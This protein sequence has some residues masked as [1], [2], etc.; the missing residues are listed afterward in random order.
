MRLPGQARVLVERSYARLPHQAQR[1]IRETYNRVRGSVSALRS[2][3]LS[4]IMPV[5]N[6]ENYLAEAVESVLSQ[7]YRHLELI[8]VDDGSTDTSG[9]MCDEFA[10]RDRRVRVIHKV[11]G[12]LGAARN[13]G[14]EAVRGSYLC[15][16][17]SDD[18]VLPGAYATMMKSILDSG[19]DIATGNVQRRRGASVYQAWNQSRSHL[20][21]QR[22]IA[23]ADNPTLLFDT[24][25]WN[26]IFRTDFWKRYVKTFPEKKLYED[27]L[28]MFTAFINARSIDIISQYVYIW[29]VRDEGDSIT[30]RL[31]EPNNIDDRFEMI[32]KI[33]ADI[34]ARGMQ[35]SLGE[36][37]LL[38]ILEGDLWIYV[39]EM[40]GAGDETIGRIIEYVKK[41][42]TSAPESVRGLIA[43]ERRI[44]YWLLEHDRVAEVALFR[45]WYATISNSPPL[46]HGSARLLLDVSDCPVPLGRM[47]D[48]CRDMVLDAEGIA[49]VTR[50]S[51]A[52][53]AT[54]LI[55]GYAYTKYV[56]TGS[57]AITVLARE[58]ATG[59]VVEFGATRTES[60][61]AMGHA[62]DT[63]SAHDHDGF[64]CTVDLQAL[65]GEVPDPHAQWSFAVRI[66]DGQ[67]VRT[68][69]LQKIW[70]GGSAVVVGGQLLADR[71][72]ALVKT[73]R[74]LPLR[75]QY[76]PVE[77][78]AASVEVEQNRVRV[79]LDAESPQVTAVQF[80]TGRS[81]PP[82]VA[83]RAA[84]GS[85]EARFPPTDT[86]HPVR[87]WRAF[88]HLGSR[89][90]PIV[91]PTGFPAGTGAN[92]TGVRAV[93]TRA[94]RLEVQVLKHAAVIEHTGSTE[95]GDIEIAGALFGVASDVEFGI[96]RGSAQ[97][98]MWHPATIEN[99]QFR[100]LITPS[101]PDHHGV[102]RP[103][104]PGGYSVHARQRVDMNG[105]AVVVQ[106]LLSDDA[107]AQLP[108]TH[109]SESLK[110]KLVRRSA[111]V[112]GADIAAPV[113]DELLGRYPQ[114]SL[115]AHYGQQ[116]RQLEDAVFFVVDR[117]SNASDSA[118]AIHHELR[119]R[120]SQL[121]LYWGV[122]G[123]HVA[124]PEGGIPIIKN[125]EQWYAKLNTARYIV[126]NYGGVWGLTKD[127]EQR[128]L[129][130]WHG[131]PYKY[132]GV[133]EARHKNAPNS[134]L[135]QIAK[136]ASEWDALV[137]PSPYFS[138]LASPEFL[139]QGAILEFGYPRNDRLATGSERERN[140]LRESLG[141]PLGAPVLLYA[142]TYRETQ[143][144]GW[145]AEMFDGLD[146]GAL[147]RLLGPNWRVLVRGHS[148]NARDE[149]SEHEASQLI[150]LTTYPDIN[151]LYLAS[152]VL[153]TDYSSTMFDYAVTGKPI[154]F[155]TPDLVKYVATR[156]AYF[157]LAVNAPGPLITE[158]TH[159]A[160]AL[161]NL[162][163]VAAEHR[164]A[165]AA[166][167]EKF[168]P[169]DDGK[170]TARV[171]DA[172][173]H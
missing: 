4:V 119:R 38:K 100:A 42:F 27:I 105:A 14:I 64:E 93:A 111:D 70:R 56:S 171:V 90:V 121:T 173:F 110:I 96:A 22:A 81:R 87:T 88:A 24:V 21:D 50:L 47:P 160:D 82:V 43:A 99:G 129:Q 23:L 85:F 159:L 30:Q 13:T 92:A 161:R 169:W 77:V 131:T 75:V 168:A 120:G 113:A 127:P 53:P 133:S 41:Y 153:V 154:L 19:S 79:R 136:E 109:L 10:Q 15:F 78:V 46:E 33:Y 165:Y 16:I 144:R 80:S 103:L 35:H 118:L 11:N 116:P 9:E 62:G 137:S 107:S 130:T 123:F 12:G 125:S 91:V 158:V 108:A 141:I 132:I 164:E 101:S 156:G 26:K 124:V 155:F 147:A 65:R 157:D 49:N 84:D 166:F 172:F 143:R 122:E 106:S 32:G 67:I 142:P 126:N 5:Y 1:A 39:R 102:V 94:R 74:R 162:E 150:D 20:V 17:D 148:F 25:A 55:V 34:C 114:T 8:L 68:V 89:E 60:R 134:R 72:L 54:L 63:A 31:L 61:Y 7:S 163:T 44:I 57:Q 69:E 18:Y 58:A 139:Y 149:V 76:E 86:A 83:E 138:A 52:D 151:D 45:E 97:P 170:A 66:E 40:G 36:R 167:R 152:D 48:D 104:R 117:G 135:E 71:S 59:K 95:S 145:R 98:E 115:I 146:L 51:W 128:Y 73:D 140:Q 112:L 37:L 6:V 2:P 3:L 28:P 29:R